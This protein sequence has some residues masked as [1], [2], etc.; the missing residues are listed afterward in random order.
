[1]WPAIR[2]LVVLR[3]TSLNQAWAIDDLETMVPTVY[4]QFLEGKRSSKFDFHSE[5]AFSESSLDNNIIIALIILVY[6]LPQHLYLSLL[7]TRYNLFL[8]H[9]FYTTTDS[10]ICFFVF[11][12][13]PN[14]MTPTMIIGSHPILIK[15]PQLKKNFPDLSFWCWFRVPGLGKFWLLQSASRVLVYIQC[16]APD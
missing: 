4:H 2:C 14:S 12:I 16:C 5:C 13:V 10:V 3:S 7:I 6:L 15:L 9:F 8:S 1:M 11:L